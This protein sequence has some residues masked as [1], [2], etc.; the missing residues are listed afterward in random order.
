MKSSV[1]TVFTTASCSAV[2]F[3]TGLGAIVSVRWM[4]EP[5][6]VTTSCSCAIAGA[7]TARPEMRVLAIRQ[8]FKEVR[9]TLYPSE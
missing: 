8:A 6:T 4:R 9:L 7:A 1:L 5:V 2:T 3:V